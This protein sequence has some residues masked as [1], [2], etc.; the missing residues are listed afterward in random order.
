LN[1]VAEAAGLQR[2]SLYYHFTSREQLAEELLRD[3]W[4]RTAGLVKSS[5]AALPATAPPVDRLSAAIS[6]HLVSLLG[7]GGYTAGLVHVLAQVPEEVRAHSLTFRR[8]Y[9]RYWR[10]LARAAQEAGDIRPD[11]HLPSVVL[12]IMGALNWSVEWYDPRGPLAPDT[13]AQQVLSMVLDG[14][15]TSRTRPRAG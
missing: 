8:S 4:K 13:L 10:Q 15:A 11:L 6:A 3:A 12:I 1:D 2:G 14:L 9:L 5:V 7:E